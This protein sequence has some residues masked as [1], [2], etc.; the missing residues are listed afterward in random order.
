MCQ[1][2][3]KV[4]IKDSNVLPLLPLPRLDTLAHADSPGV[5][6]VDSGICSLGPFDCQGIIDTEKG[7]LAWLHHHGARPDTAEWQRSTGPLRRLWSLSFQRAPL[8]RTE[9]A[10]LSLSYANSNC[11]QIRISR[12]RDHAGW[13]QRFHRQCRSRHKIVKPRGNDFRWQH[14]L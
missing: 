9:D 5:D 3:H 4:C 12:E 13:E 7:G 10:T 14:G 11:V 1:R 8:Y 2:W 6:T